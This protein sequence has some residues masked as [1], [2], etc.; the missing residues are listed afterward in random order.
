MCVCF[1]V[2]N[3]CLVVEYKLWQ[4]LYS[5]EP[6]AKYRAKDS[7]MRDMICISI[8]EVELLSYACL[9]AINNFGLNIGQQL[10]VPKNPVQHNN[11]KH[12]EIDWFFV[13]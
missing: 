8:L 9:K 5:G 11:T 4:S 7:N 12:V 6:E 13:K 3:M 1:L 10:R 2:V